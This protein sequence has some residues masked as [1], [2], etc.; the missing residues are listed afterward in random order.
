MPLECKVSRYN[1]RQLFI[2]TLSANGFVVLAA[3]LFQSQFIMLF[4]MVH[5]CPSNPLIAVIEIS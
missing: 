4:H 2:E 3:I 5:D 1:V